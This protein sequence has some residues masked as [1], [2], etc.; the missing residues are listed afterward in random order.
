[1]DKV[2]IA[3]NQIQRGMVLKIIHEAQPLGA[4]LE[5]I[6]AVLK[7]HGHALDRE[8]VMTLCK[9][10]EGKQLIHIENLGNAI[11][12]LNRD[13]AHITPQG[14]DVLEGTQAVE[15]IALVD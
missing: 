12:K 15:G 2:Q 1:M 4:G 5:V 14:I 6:T 11:L 7:Q 9:Y 10:L 13:I 3:T 8:A